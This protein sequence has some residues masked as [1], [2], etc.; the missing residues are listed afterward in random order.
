MWANENWTRRW[1]GADED[2]L[3][4]QDHRPEDELPLIACF[5]RHFAD[6]RYIRVGHRPLL[7]IYRIGL[8]PDARD[9]IARWRRLFQEHAGEDPLFVMSQSFGDDDPREYGID[10]AVE[11]PPHKLVGG[12]ATINPSLNVLDSD[13]DAQVY[14]YDEVVEQ[15][16]AEPRRRSR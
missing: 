8:I 15:A 9:T 4:A 16:L 7:M 11:F 13:F 2:V 3:I 5:A 1:D 10:G 12:L 6:P 14:D